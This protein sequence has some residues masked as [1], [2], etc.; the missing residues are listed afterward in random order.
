MLRRPHE[1]TETDFRP[2]QSLMSFV[3]DWSNAAAGLRI[4]S[5]TLVVTTASIGRVG[6][7]VAML[8]S[9][10]R[11]V[12][13]GPLLV[14]N[15]VTVIVVDGLLDMPL[16]AVKPTSIA[17]GSQNRTHDLPIGSVNLAVGPESGYVSRLVIDRLVLHSIHPSP[18]A[19]RN[20]HL[21]ITGLNAERW[22]IGAKAKLHA[23]ISWRT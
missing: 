18:W 20:V 8:L 23:T 9:G 19:Q 12:P 15:D 13:D 4:Q 3:N 2:I 22:T 14:S 5:C 10:K 1:A 11:V 7:N 21:T 17:T 16:R 6:F